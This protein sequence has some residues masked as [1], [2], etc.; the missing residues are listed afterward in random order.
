MHHALRCTH[1]RAPFVP[2][3]RVKAQRFC[4]HPAC[5]RA[6]KTPWQRD[7][8]AR[9]PDYRANQRDCQRHWQHQH[10]Q[11]WREYRQRRAASRARHRLW[12]QP[13]DHKRRARPLAQLDAF[14]SI[15]CIEPRDVS[16]HPRRGWRAGQSWPG[17]RRTGMGCPVTSARLQQRT[18]STCLGSGDSI[19]G[20][21]VPSGLTKSPLAP[22]RVRK[23]TGRFAVLAHR[24]IRDGFWTSLSHQAVLLYVF[25]VLVAD[26]NGLSYYS[27]DKI[28]VLLQLSLDDDL[29]ARH[30]LIK[31]DRIAFDGHLLPV[32]SLPPTPMLQPA[33]PLHTRARTWHQPT[34][35]PLRHIIRHSLGA[36]H[37]LTNA[38]SSRATAWPMQVSPCA[39]WRGPWALPAAQPRNTST[40]PNPPRPHRRRPSLLEPFHAA[41]ERLLQI[42]SHR[43][44][45]GD[46]SASRGPGLSRGPQP[47]TAVFA[48]GTRPQNA[49]AHHPFCNAP[50]PPVPGR[51]GPLWCP[52]LWQHR[53]QTLLPGRGGRA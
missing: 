43:L 48:P 44:R 22:A 14:A 13:R 7:T 23:I 16:S 38:P 26:R 49:K 19:T 8:L 17:Y 42:E 36:D 24:C 34:P 18:C 47:L 11:Y 1:C 46:S 39:R 41:I 35:P 20:Q 45:R 4:A 6:R 32:L 30:A 25:L 52:P 31:K 28:C 10:P 27:V 37:A 15:P 51:L 50:R 33:R 12:H 3:P 53:A 40:R 9:D 21:E 5:Q 2:N 29:I